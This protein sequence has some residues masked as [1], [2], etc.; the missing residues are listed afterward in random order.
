[1]SRVLS[2]LLDA[3]GTALLN[4]DLPVL[5]AL[6]AGVGRDR[7]G[8]TRALAR[9]LDRPRRALGPI[10][11]GPTVWHCTLRRG[12]YL[13]G[14]P[15]TKWELVVDSVVTEMR[16]TDRAAPARWLA[17][18]VIADGE[19]HRVDIVAS[20]VREDGTRVDRWHD[21]RRA[22]TAA[23]RHVTGEGG[24]SGLVDQGHPAAD[25]VGVAEFARAAIRVVNEQ[26]AQQHR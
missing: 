18:Y 8:T 4:A 26:L 13:S 12:G 19:V 6:L 16:F 20:L 11:A 21:Y 14:W 22:R 17:S 9:S 25:E 23:T 24:R 7:G 2:R 5:A 15:S 3:P 10:T 1:M